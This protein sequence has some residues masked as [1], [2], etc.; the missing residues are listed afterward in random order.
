MSFLIFIL[1]IRRSLL[2]ASANRIS[3]HLYYLIL[4]TYRVPVFERGPFLD[5]FVGRESFS[6]HHDRRHCA[7]DLDVNV[8]VDVGDI[9][10][11][12]FV[13]DL[14]FL[15]EIL[16]VGYALR[17]HIVAANR[18]L[19]LACKDLIGEKNAVIFML[20]DVRG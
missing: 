16:T 12:N 13:D 3:Y 20:L 14:N 5:L 15:H 19:D 9:L 8:N 18:F 17:D 6:R 4:R 10:T 2:Q 11:V 1:D 7:A